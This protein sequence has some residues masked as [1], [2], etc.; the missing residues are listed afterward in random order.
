MSDTSILPH[1]IALI[2]GAWVVYYSWKR[3]ATPGIKLF[4]WYSIGYVLW[5][6]A[7]IFELTSPALEIKLFWDTFQWIVVMVAV[8]ALPVFALL[9]KNRDLKGHEKN[10]QITITLSVMLTILIVVDSLFKPRFFETTILNSTHTVDQNTFLFYVLAFYC[11][12]IF[13]WGIRIL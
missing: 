13:A 11:Y 9:Y 12:V 8:P 3:S 5:M 1:M 7:F 6:S 4:L 10:I 2:I